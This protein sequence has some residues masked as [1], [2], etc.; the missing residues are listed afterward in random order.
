[1]PKAEQRRLT[2]GGGDAVRIA[3]LEEIIRAHDGYTLEARASWI[4][5]GLGIPVPLHRQPLATLSGGF[6]LRVLLAQVLD[7]WARCAASRRA[8]ES[9]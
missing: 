6:K 4:L 1:M 2:D 3:D 8:N 7:R 9:S 5:E